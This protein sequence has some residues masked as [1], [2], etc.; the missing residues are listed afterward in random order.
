[1]ET[2]WCLECGEELTYFF[3]GDYECIDCEIMYSEDTL[4]ELREESD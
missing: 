3:G 1:M 4:R 2:Y